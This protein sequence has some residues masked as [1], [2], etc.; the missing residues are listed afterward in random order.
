MNNGYER[1]LSEMYRA[2]AQEEPPESIDNM[3]LA[4]ARRE[5]PQ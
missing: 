1:Q 3:I 5:L 4:T 2:S